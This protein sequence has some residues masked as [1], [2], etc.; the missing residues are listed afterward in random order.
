MAAPEA[1]ASI[2][3]PCTQGP[4]H[5]QRS[6][7]SRPALDGYPYFGILDGLNLTRGSVSSLKGI[8]GDGFTMQISAPVQ[9]GN[10]GGPLLNEYGQVV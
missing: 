1:E 9:P 3:H 4:S 8:G 10:S 2:D 5:S 6:C 7:I